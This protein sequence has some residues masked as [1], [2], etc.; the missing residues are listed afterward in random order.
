MASSAGRQMVE[1]YN[2]Y[3]WQP[4][5]T[6]SIDE[7]YMDLTLL[8]TRSSKL[9]NGSMA[10]ILVQHIEDNNPI[11][12]S[13]SKYLDAVISVS[14][15]R[16]LYKD[17]ESDIHAEI[18]A[19]GLAAC[20]G[21]ATRHCTAYITM[22]PCRKC[23]AALLCAGVRRIVTR[24]DSPLLELAATYS[25]EMITLKDWESHKSRTDA[26]VQLYEEHL[27]TGEC[28]ESS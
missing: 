1:R 16:A 14:T 24:H 19:I 8:I 17:N 20:A 15:N 26:F 28:L 11:E 5:P 12:C 2:T 21:Y 6:I 13:I 27:A 7:N 18:S 22:P 25:I 4:N 10:C 23:F 9:K 3:M